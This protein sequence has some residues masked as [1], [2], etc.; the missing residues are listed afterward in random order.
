VLDFQMVSEMDPGKEF[1]LGFPRVFARELV[2][3]FV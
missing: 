3:E 1:E 2:K